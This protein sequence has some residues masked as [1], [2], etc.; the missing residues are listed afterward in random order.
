MK[1][2][3]HCRRR[4]GLEAWLKQYSICLAVQRSEFK[5]TTTKRWG[6]GKNKVNF[7]KVLFK[8]TSKNSL[9][10]L[11]CLCLFFNK[12]SHKGRTGW[13]LPETE[14]GRGEKV[15]KRSRVEK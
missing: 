9:S 13:D 1:L 15:G 14:E 5:I 11:L 2:M 8:N 4:E 6:K 7:L 12:I 10:F 3:K